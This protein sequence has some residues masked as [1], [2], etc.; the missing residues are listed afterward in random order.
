MGSD[1][2]KKCVAKCGRNRWKT[3]IFRPKK[4][5]RRFSN[6]KEEYDDCTQELDIKYRVNTY[7][8]EKYRENL[9]PKCGKHPIP[10]KDCF[11]VIPKDYHPDD[12]GIL[13]DAMS[14]FGAI[15]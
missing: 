10:C 3:K 11:K 2:L 12:G 8:P 14:I 13:D 4:G 1:I 7:E 6:L 9:V 15:G 5:E